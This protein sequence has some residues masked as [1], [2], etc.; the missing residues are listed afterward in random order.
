M[1]YKILSLTKKDFRIDVF[2]PGGNGGQ[3]MQKT[4]SGVRITH[5]PS[6]ATGQATDTRSYHENRKLAFRRMY[7]SKRFQSWLR[8][9][10]ATVS[11]I[12]DKIS[13]DTEI[14]SVENL[15]IEYR[16]N[17][18]WVEVDGFTNLG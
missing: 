13:F 3:K 12:N 7:E 6:G 5:P 10:T 2:R 18:K 4:S 14:M 17:G 16:Q 11:Y 1:R 15:R 8:I 9:E